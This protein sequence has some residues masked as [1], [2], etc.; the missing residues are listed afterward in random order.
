M[1]AL[2]GVGEIL[3]S[4]TTSEDVSEEYYDIEA[5][6]KSKHIEEAR[7]I[8]HLK[9]STARL[10]DI[11]AVEKEISRVQEEVERMEGRRRFLASQTDFS[12]VTIT[13]RELAG[14]TP[15]ESPSL[16]T[17]IG[18]TF[19]A[20]VAALGDFGRTLA[21]LIVSLLPW[22]T[23]GAGVGIPLW[24]MARRRQRKAKPVAAPK[25]PAGDV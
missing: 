11:L 23:V 10:T 20:S 9:H 19:T 14:I 12:T 24:Q 7:L 5:R 1:A 13:V 4:N 8:D 2:G 18:R 22:A 17:Q 6:L 21:L 3:S 16:G 15:R 25:P